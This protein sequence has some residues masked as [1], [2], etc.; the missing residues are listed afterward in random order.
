MAPETIQEEEGEDLEEQASAENTPENGSQEPASASQHPVQS[1][2]A[3]GDKPSKSNGPPPESG[4]R[5]PGS[6][7]IAKPEWERNANI[8]EPSQH[9]VEKGSELPEDGLNTKEANNSRS[10]AIEAG[11]P[12]TEALPRD[13]DIS[14]S[15]GFSAAN[16]ANDELTKVESS[17]SEKRISRR[18]INKS[19][20]STDYQ[21]YQDA[22]ESLPEVVV[23][24]VGLE[25]SREGMQD[26]TSHPEKMR[27]NTSIGE[28]SAAL[29]GEG[30]ALPTK[31][32]LETS[33][34]PTYPHIPLVSSKSPPPMSPT[35]SFSGIK[36]PEALLSPSDMQST[37]DSYFDINR[38]TIPPHSYADGDGGNIDN[39]SDTQSSSALRPKS[40]IIDASQA[41][42]T[43]SS[44]DDFRPNTASTANFSGFTQ[45]GPNPAYISRNPSHTSQISAAT[46][47]L[48]N[49]FPHPHGQSFHNGPMPGPSPTPPFEIRSTNRQSSTNRNRPTSLVSDGDFSTLGYDEQQQFEA[50]RPG[51]YT[52]PS[53]SSI[54]EDQPLANVQTGPTHAIRGGDTSQSPSR[55]GSINAVTAL[56][57][58]NAA[59]ANAADAKR[60]GESGPWS[61]ISSGANPVAAE[62]NMQ[63]YQSNSGQTRMGRDEP[64]TGENNAQK[65]ARSNNKLAKKGTVGATTTASAADV[66]RSA[67][68]QPQ[69]ANKAT[70]VK[71]KRTSLLGSLFGRSST[72]VP[73][74]E[75][76]NSAADVNFGG[77]KSSKLV[78]KG[79]K[80]NLVGGHG[81]REYQQEQRPPPGHNQASAQ[82]PPPPPRPLPAG[83]PFQGQYG[84]AQQ[85]P[86]LPMPPAY[87]YGG[88]G[89]Y[90]PMTGPGPM[91][92]QPA[93][94]NRLQPKPTARL[95]VVGPAPGTYPQHY[96]ST[97]GAPSF[98]ESS[99]DL[100]SSNAHL[101]GAAGNRDTARGISERDDNATREEHVT[102]L[103]S[104]GIVPE[105]PPP[106][107]V[108]TESSY[109]AAA[110]RRSVG[111]HSRG[112]STDS[113]ATSA[114]GETERR[115][116]SSYVSGERGSDLDLDQQRSYDASYNSKRSSYG[117]DY[118]FLWN[119]NPSVA[120]SSAQQSQNYNQYQQQ[121]PSPSV[122]MNRYYARDNSNSSSG[123]TPAAP[124]SAL[125][126]RSTAG[127]MPAPY[128]A[129]PPQLSQLP[130]RIGASPSPAPHP[131]AYAG[132]EGQM[133]ADSQRAMKR[134]S[135]APELPQ[136]P[137]G[138]GDGDED[139][140]KE[141]EMGKST[142]ARRLSN[143]EKIPVV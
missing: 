109:S 33:I 127:S 62:Q 136:L 9:R 75:T 30:S 40:I 137:E 45:A 130:D 50:A 92:R 140:E 42:H 125:A 5:A 65:A 119:A 60:R 76:T 27:H 115:R 134:A 47:D 19:F 80:S 116:W 21:E 31:A 70:P 141:A 11:I 94:Q 29:S 57:M 106:A 74:T 114:E 103:R 93:T 14:E 1:A 118:E 28:V 55:R 121:R 61:E 126:R 63:Q 12:E 98:T 26:S 124:T 4:H 110:K 101:S 22:L 102:Y 108:R 39:V 84:Y 104:Q 66:Q 133:L 7:S 112:Y 138:V 113:H 68:L 86:L 10:T 88:N 97:P 111:S 37:R 99:Y 89:F 59:L 100:A 51:L 95:P 44:S 135:T 69:A 82:M 52:H 78:K 17:Q 43:A 117:S 131:R 96:R 72:V 34:P 36:S 18:P 16:I 41:S 139:E 79:S 77:A 23:A 73:L 56:A 142:N 15:R 54:S 81:S 123:P 48:Y 132:A 24:P 105:R 67:T 32:P 120:P 90:Q 35:T 107:P 20:E 58:E 85:P 49:S 64:S 25:P 128:Q 91:Q 13:N 3:H 6:A 53:V 8:G 2:K 38:A 71:K 87:Q 129:N 46:P 83:A 122:R 143:E